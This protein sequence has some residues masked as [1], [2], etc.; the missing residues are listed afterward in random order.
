MTKEAWNP[1]VHTVALYEKEWSGKT[2]LAYD[3]RILLMLSGGAVLEC[4]DK[5]LR[6]AP[7]NLCLI[8][9]ACPYKC[10]CDY[11]R[12]LYITFD[13]LPDDGKEVPAPALPEVF[14]AEEA[15]VAGFEAPLDRLIFLEDMAAESE[16]LQKL[17]DLFVSGMGEYR[18]RASA[19][20]KLLLL[21][22]AE[23]A[24]EDAL[25][26]RL[27]E[28]LDEYIREN[29]CDDISNTE[30]GAIFGYHP[31]YISQIL[32]K[33]L[34]M[35]LRQY[36]ISY[37]LRR[38]AQMLRET[39]KTIGEISEECGFSDASYFTKS[40]RAAFGISPK[41]YRLPYKDQLI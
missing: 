36:I 24:D 15:R 37:R 23:A 4:G 14:K 28:S 33:K 32:K 27:I 2:H 5:R 17:H 35:T 3:G 31:F 25:P 21:K 8:P 6:L 38:A 16:G 7:G 40:F 41:D 18:A 11:A 19:L 34:G 26:T 30:V 12:F 10:K 20:V 13:F 1:T 29:A 39:G 9:P 22:I